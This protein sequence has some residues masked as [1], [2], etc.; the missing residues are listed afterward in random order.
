MSVT[1][2]T[3]EIRYESEALPSSVPTLG[4]PQHVGSRLTVGRSDVDEVTPAE[5]ADDPALAALLRRLDPGSALMRLTLRL[6]FRPASDEMFEGAL[7]TVALVADDAPVENQPTAL[8]LVPDRL[9]SG[10]FTVQR[11][12]TVSAGTD[13]LPVHL[14]A[15]WSQSKA[16]ELAPAYVVAAGLGETDPEWRYARTETMALEGSHEMI[17][18]V[19]A[20][21]QTRSRAALSLGGTVRRGH[22]SIEVQWEAEATLASIELAGTPAAGMD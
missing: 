3:Q 11:G 13:G 8:L 5:V 20:R 7:L 12:L 1:L 2:S 14:E 4:A 19:D 15:Q 16:L 21:R 17:L 22:H 18:L 10:P 9:A 6:S